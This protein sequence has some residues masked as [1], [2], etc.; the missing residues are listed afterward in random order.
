MQAN[1]DALLKKYGDGTDK[2]LSV[3]LMRMRSKDQDIRKRL[4]EDQNFQ[5]LPVE[6][7]EKLAKQMNETDAAL[8]AR[9]KQIVEEKGWPTIP[10]VGEDASKA[11]ALILVHTPDHVWQTS[12]LP[13]LEH[14]AEQD[15]ITGDDIAP[16]VDRMLKAEGKPQRFGT[17]F[18]FKDGVMTMWP[19]EDPAHLDELREQYQLPPMDEY[20]KLMAQ[21]YHMK[22]Q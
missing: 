19:V 12:L 16:I 20:K 22:A 1:H 3:E 11:A 15:M 21:Y 14:L 13:A 4:F 2:A 5:S 7:Q 9:L 8:T 17:Y 6:Q 10:L 18:D